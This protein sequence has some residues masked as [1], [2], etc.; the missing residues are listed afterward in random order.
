MIH[1]NDRYELG[2]I[3]PEN[4]L[5]YIR[6]RIRQALD[7]EEIIA[8]TVTEL[9]LFLGT[10]RVMMYKFHPDASG[11]VIAE[12]T[13]SHYL[14]SLLGLNFPADDIPA[15]A[16]EQYIKSRVRSVINVD[17]RQVGQSKLANLYNREFLDDDINYRSVEP[18]HL[19]Y[20]N[21]MGVKRSLVVPIVDRDELWGLLVFHHSKPYI[22]TNLEIDVV[23]VVADDLTV[24]I[25]QHDFLSQANEKALRDTVINRVANR[26][27]SL[28]TIEFQ[29]AL[30]EVVKAFSGTG[31]R[32][33]I[34]DKVLSDENGALWSFTKSLEASGD[35]VET[36]TYGKQPIIADPAYPLM[37][38]SVVWQEHYK[39]KKYDVWAIS[40]IYQ[41]PQ[42][43]NLQSS[44]QP[45]K[46]RGILMI[47]LDHRQQLLGYMTIFRDEV[48]SETLWAGQ[49][50]PDSRQMYPR[51][52]FEVWR[53]TKKAQAPEWLAKDI[54][55]ARALSKEFARAV[56]E[57]H[58]DQQAYQQSSNLEIKVRE[59]TNKI[60]QRI[61]QQRILF[62]V[63]T[64]IR[65]SL[66]L[67]SIFDTTTKEVC[68]SLQADRVAVYRFNPDWS[69]KVVAEFV[70]GDW[71]KLFD[72]DIIASLW[73]DT[74]LQES[75]GGRYR[76]NKTS[77]V[78]DIY[79]AGFSDCYLEILEKFQA[80]AYAIAPIFIGQKLWGLLAAYQNSGPRN[81]KKH[82]I[83]FMIQTATQFG[84]ALQQ[85]TLVTKIQQQR[86]HFQQLTQ[87]Q[88]LWFEIVSQIR[89]SSN[90]ETIFRTTIKKLCQLLKAERIAVYR[91]NPDG[92]GEFVYD[93]TTTDLSLGNATIPG[94]PNLW[95][96][97]YL[98]DIQREGYGNH[99]TFAV[100]D[101]YKVGLSNHDIETL[102]QFSIMAYAI[103]PI[104]VGRKLWGLLMAYQHS[105]PRQWKT[106]EIKI[107][108]EAANLFGITVHQSELI[109]KNKHMELELQPYQEMQAS[110]EHLQSY[111]DDDIFG[112]SM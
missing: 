14:P 16:R 59:R 10:D 83:Q 73:Q 101:I 54:E 96:Y 29:S 55:L 108:T 52:S 15:S 99:K 81:W 56:H 13:N 97:S 110:L 60:S 36:Y 49:F 74:C 106:S 48:D 62:E 90:V 107:I 51:K 6:N 19:E 4:F 89:E 5:R 9:R 17:T 91:F 70:N 43:Q 38:Q 41:T 82:E 94:T 86:N 76:Q 34:L 68:Q 72:V 46:I 61:E 87:Q 88:D 32:L 2:N 64:K 40:D 112:D 12:S 45:T 20:L 26:L 24:A 42:L 92:I 31:A 27:H 58:L 57:N 3:N 63:V 8:L 25:A 65:E 1:N 102:E 98:Q 47:P 104:L 30:Q 21:A 105:H 95:N 18:C 77:I 100:D 35:Y 37:E 7:F 78:N 28:P 71:V 109:A 39:S 22:F 69:G 67:S 93:Y 11:Q 111:S 50:D 44:F 84:V 85:G 53:E 66:D 103:V 80:R 23:Q 75:R 33:C 79:Q